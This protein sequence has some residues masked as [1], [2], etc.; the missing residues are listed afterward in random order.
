MQNNNT[1]SADSTHRLDRL[2][3]PKSI[4]LVGVSPRPGTVGN[5][6]LKVL[7]DGGYPGTV[8]LVN[9]RYE[10]IAGTAC[11]SSMT[12]I[13]DTIDMAVLSV[14]GARM[15]ALVDEAI[16]LNVGGLTIYDY[17]KIKGESIDEES[18]DS[19]LL[20][21]LKVKAEQAGMPICGGNCM[22]YYNF[23][24]DTHVSFQSPGQRKPGHISLIAHSGSIFVLPT[25]NDP[26]FRFNLVVSAGQ[27]I[28][29]SLDDYMDFALEQESTRVLAVFMEAVRNPQGFIKVLEKALLKNIPVVVTKVGRTEASAKLAAT[30]SGAIAGNNTVYE[31]LFKKYGVICT[32]TLDDL[33]NTA[34]LLSQGIELDTGELGYITDSGGLRELFVDTSEQYQ[35]PFAQI[36]AETAGKLK[37]RLPLGLDPVNPL[38]AAGSFT[39][40]F[41]N[42]FRDCIRHVMDDPN[43]ALGV[44]EFEARD[45]FIYEP[46]F[47]KIAKEVKSY[48]NK[49]FFVLNSFSGA[50]NAGIADDLM[51]HEVPLINGVESGVKAIK[52]VLDLRDFRMRAQTNE[53]HEVT[54]FT[55]QEQAIADKWKSRICTGKAL[56]ETDSLTLLSEFGLAVATPIETESLSQTIS[57]AKNTGFPLVL[58]TAEPGIHHKSDVGGVRLNITNIEEV[59]RVYLDMEAN[60]GPRVAVEPMVAEGTEMAFGMLNDPQFGPMVMVGAGGIYIEILKDRC[61]SLAPFDSAEAERMLNQ[62][63]IRPLLEGTR[64]RATC[65]LNALRDS[66][67]RFSRLVH[68]LGDV[69]EEVDI[70]PLIV[71]HKGCV[72]VDALVIGK[73]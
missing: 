65:D 30:H 15:E 22:G 4:A 68:L 13:P 19:S 72:A 24:T 50:L 43:V 64:G 40:D 36:T 8:Y 1:S 52:N 67:V 18:R 59:E 20:E 60:L 71:D 28:S 58:K 10:E 25:S 23:E 57:A 70:N 66:L 44:F 45:E 48:S 14:T 55:E 51:D 9:P 34:L 3:K 16:G 38:D 21:R 61:F 47:I 46:E 62:L 31:A 33:M 7:N 5:D 12:D 69:I 49:P 6:M 42:V 32:D 37:K 29:T 73:N 26:R 53:R 27:E 41:A 11:F 63:K 35:V 54:S 56:S 39:P 17:C 2:L